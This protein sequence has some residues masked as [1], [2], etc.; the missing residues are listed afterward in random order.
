MRDVTVDGFSSLEKRWFSSESDGK[1]TARPPPPCWVGLSPP[2]NRST[3]EL[4]MSGGPVRLLVSFCVV[5]GLFVVDVVVDVVVEVVDSVVAMK[6][7][8]GYA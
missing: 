3:F 5:V 6:R 2:G 7:C 1:G 8:K 4:E